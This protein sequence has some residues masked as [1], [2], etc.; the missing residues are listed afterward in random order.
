[1]YVIVGSLVWVR[2]N[3]RF[4]IHG[5]DSQPGVTCKDWREVNPESVNT[6]TPH[7]KKHVSEEKV[8]MKSQLNNLS[9]TSDSN[10]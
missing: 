2:F 6:W 10:D 1:M 9:I 3:F 7:I 8:E 4:N 5:T